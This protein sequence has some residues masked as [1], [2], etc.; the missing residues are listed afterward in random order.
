MSNPN[1]YT[2]SYLLADIRRRGQIPETSDGSYGIED[3]CAMASDEVQGYMT[4]LLMGV[5]EEWF[6]RAYD[7]NL[8]GNQV[9][10]NIPKRSVGSK[11]R[12]VL[13]G[14]EPNWLVV[15]RVEP[16][17]TYGYYYGFTPASFPNSGFGAGYI[18][19]NTSIKLLSVNYGGPTLR[20]MYFFRP[21]RVVP[22][23]SCGLITAI[24][25]NTN[26]VTIDEVPANG[27][28]TDGTLYD[29]I[30]SQP[31]FDTLSF[32]QE[33]NITGNVLTFTNSLPDG[34]EVGDYIALAGESPIPQLP[35]E[36]H[37]LLAQR[38]V[39]KVL[40]GMGD[41]KVEVAKRMCDEQRE[42]AL[43]LLTPR[44]EGDARYLTNFNGP[45]WNARFRYGS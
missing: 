28:F 20:M 16:K 19:Q 24:D 21:N 9:T 3:L 4:S 11:L 34:L 32:D 44:S 2:A 1:P 39:V 7:Q 41:P 36:L 31:G 26:E 43:V 13:I 10:Y 22:E 15:Q 17:Q 12:Q 37:Q 33:A 18:F 25:T 45:G 14:Q 23:T 40:E 38:V 8:V 35:V 27:T 42:A 6:V 5:R 29:F 30:K